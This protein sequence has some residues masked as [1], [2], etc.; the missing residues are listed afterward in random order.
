M[1]WLKKA[2]SHLVDLHGKTFPVPAEL[3]VSARRFDKEKLSQE[4]LYTWE[5]LGEGTLPSKTQELMMKFCD[6]IAS[7]R[8][9]VFSHRDYHTRN[10]M[11]HNNKVVFIDFQDAR[12]GPPHYDLAS[13]VYDAYIP[14]SSE[15]REELIGQYQE[16]LKKYDLY[17]K[18]DWNLFKK[19]LGKV[20]WQRMVKAA[21]SFA[22]FFK[23]H[24]KRTHLPF[25]TPALSVAI[26]LAKADSDIPNLFPLE[27]WRDKKW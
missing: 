27:Q 13:L 22:S 3:P 9:L 11:L 17:S 26:Q 12:L 1:A 2:I 4:L 6:E 7:I 5:N 21:G 15:E 10:L 8:P 23:K 20:A 14:L 18:I 19:D 24:Q 25:L 16:E